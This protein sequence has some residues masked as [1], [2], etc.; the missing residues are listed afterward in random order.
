MAQTPNRKIERMWAVIAENEEPVGDGVVAI[1][2]VATGGWTPLITSEESNLE[3]LKELAL[4]NKTGRKFLVRQFTC[5][6]EDEVICEGT[7]S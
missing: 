4:A 2:S 7:D 5:V 3:K 6:G 1:Y